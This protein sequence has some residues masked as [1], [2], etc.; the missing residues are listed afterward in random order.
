MCEIKKMSQQNIISIIEND[1]K[2]LIEEK[3]ILSINHTKIIEE[4]RLHLEL[5]GEI[6]DRQINKIDVINHIS[7]TE[8]ITLETWLKDTVFHITDDELRTD[9]QKKRFDL[10]VERARIIQKIVAIDN[11][12]AKKN[13]Q[14]KKIDSTRDFIG[15]ETW[16]VNSLEAYGKIAS[17]ERKLRDWID[18]IWTNHEIKYWN[19]SNFFNE[20]RKKEIDGEIKFLNMS[21]SNVRK[22]DFADFSDYE[23]I[24]NKEKPQFTRN[25]FFGGNVEKQRKMITHLADIR[26]LRNTVMH[27]PPLNDEEHKRLDVFYR[28]IIEIIESSKTGL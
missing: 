12:F 20:S 11:E 26:K 8:K 3:N 27:R 17:L 1:I 5:M 18:D 24:L 10:E 4:L 2:N 14:L 13:Q 23:E 15:M 21:N 25:R 9:D 6:D 16:D 28:E 7:D 22:I 19:D